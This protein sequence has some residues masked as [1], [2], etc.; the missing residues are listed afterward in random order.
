[1]KG[2]YSDRSANMELG[3]GDKL[4]GTAVSPGG[5]GV[6]WRGTLHMTQCVHD[7]PPM[8]TAHSPLVCQGQGGG[9]VTRQFS[10]TTTRRRHAQ[11]TVS[12]GWKGKESKFGPWQFGLRLD[13]FRGR[14]LNR[15]EMHIAHVDAVVRWLKPGWGVQRGRPTIF[16]RQAGE[17]RPTGELPGQDGRSCDSV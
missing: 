4:V 7:T 12:W 2:P 1:M 15:T 9:C 11:A 16:L 8:P 6:I 17:H 14:T 13:A 10:P 5:G 3:L